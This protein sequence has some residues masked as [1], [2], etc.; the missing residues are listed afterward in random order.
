MFFSFLLGFYILYITYISV[1]HL[2]GFTYSSYNWES[3][4]F[5]YLHPIP[6]SCQLPTSGN[7]KSDLFFYEFIFEV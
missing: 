3:E 5:D 7:Y 2:S 4:P 1:N 6:H